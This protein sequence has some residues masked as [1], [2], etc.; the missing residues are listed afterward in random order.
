MSADSASGEQGSSGQLHDE[1]LTLTLPEN[2]TMPPSQGPPQAS[3]AASFDVPPIRNP[4]ASLSVA[5]DPV[6]LITTECITVTAAMRKHTRW[7]HSSVS[8]I[9]GGKTGSAGH[10]LE[11]SRPSS[12]S[13]GLASRRPQISRNPS[14]STNPGGEDYGLA[15]RWGLRGK[16]GKSMQDNPLMSAFAHLRSDLAGCG[17]K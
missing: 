3:E 16:K 4:P 14:V 1:E 6:A 13:Q 2:H 10:A 7:A 15:N 5:I 12:P 17:G 9:L 11:I 8:T